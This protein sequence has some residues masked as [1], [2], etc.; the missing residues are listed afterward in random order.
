MKEFKPRDRLTQRMTRDGAVLDNQTTGEEI[1]ISERD[2]EKQLSPD[3]QPVQ[4][5][6]RDAPMNP[7][8]DAPKHGRQFRP[9]EQKEPEKE[10]PKP[11]QPSAE[12]FQ[13]QGGSPISHIPQDIPTSA[14]SGGTAEKL[15]DRAAAE[16]DAHKARQTARMSRDAAQQRYSAS[17]LQ[18]SEEERAA[19]ELHKYIHHAEKAADKLDAAQ[20]AIPKKRVL[21]KERVFDEASGTAKT[22]LRFDTVDKSPPKLKPNPL[23]RPLREVAVQAHGKIHEVEHENVGVE[24]GHKAEELAEHGAGGA[25]RWERRHRKLKPY[26]AAEKAERKAVNANAEYLYQ[27]ALYDNPEMLSGNPLNLF[28]R[29]SV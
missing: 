20:A 2:A 23:G 11:Q 25:I 19:P 29:S 28:S 4:M 14:A 5:G 24:S 6:K 10:Q 21:R 22:K 17:R 26:R 13:P 18:F 16:H 12:P 3:G 15:F 7:A 27:K 9:Q 8:E 1:H